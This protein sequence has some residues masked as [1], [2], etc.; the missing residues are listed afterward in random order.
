MIS[1]IGPFL[2]LETNRHPCVFVQEV[3]RMASRNQHIDSPNAASTSAEIWRRNYGDLGSWSYQSTIAEV[4]EREISATKG[5]NISNYNARRRRGDLLP[6]TDFYQYELRSVANPGHRTWSKYP[7]VYE[8]RDNHYKTIEG[9]TPD[10][11]DAYAPEDLDYWVQAAAANIVSQGYDWLT[12]LAELGHLRGMFS[13]ISGKFKNMF[14]RDASRSFGQMS[15]NW[16]EGRYAWRTLIYDLENFQFAYQNTDLYKRKRF[17]NREGTS[18]SL[19]LSDEGEFQETRGTVAWTKVDEVDVSSRGSVTA[20]ISIDRFLARPTITAW[21]LVPFS[22]VI[23][24]FLDVGQALEAVSFLGRVD[25]YSASVGY[26]VDLRRSETWDAVA[27]ASDHDNFD[28]HV[29]TDTEGYIERRIP[30]S[31]S[32]KPQVNIRLDEWKM[33]DLLALFYQRFGFKYR[34]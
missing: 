32:L 20:D 28:Y 9:L 24:W 5:W 29:S 14:S 8:Y 30:W 4:T 18:R 26:R 31:V 15:N 25:R 10:T 13:N 21:E 1:I 12:A 22:F 16:L 34:R 2:A 23:D 3:T 33:L 7:Y 19:V 6:H 17:S 27:P 11:I